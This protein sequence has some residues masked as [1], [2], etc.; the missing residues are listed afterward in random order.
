MAG[1]IGIILYASCFCAAGAMAQGGY[2]DLSYETPAHYASPPIQEP[3][4]PASV[5]RMGSGFADSGMV[6]PGMVDPT[7]SAP[8][9]MGEAGPIMYAQPYPG[10]GMPMGGEFV[11]TPVSP[12]SGLFL[13]NYNN[14]EAARNGSLFWGAGSLFVDAWI[15]QGLSYSN[16]DNDEQGPVGPNDSEGY[17]MNQLYLSFGRKVEKGCGW[18]FG[19]QI[20]LMYG[21]DYYYASSVGL[22]NT[23]ENAPHWNGNG[24]GSTYYRGGR[25]EY[26]LAMPQI[27]AEVYAPIFCGVDVKIG[28]FYSVMGFESPVAPM[29]FFYSRSYSSLYGMPS[30]MT[31]V[32]TTSR[33]GER[34]NLILGAV[35][36]WNA[37]DTPND[38]FSIVAGFS[39]DSWCK[40]LSFSAIVMTG[41]QNAPASGSATWSEE[42]ANTTL[43]N[44]CAILRL[45]D[46][47]SYTAE[48]VAGFDD[49]E[50]LNNIDL[51][52]F[53]GREWYGFS[54]YLFYRATEQLTLGAR[55]EWFR[56]SN[57]TVVTGGYAVSAT[58]EAADYFAFTLGANWEPNHWFVLR[59]EVRWDWSDWEVVD[60]EESRLGAYDRN[61]SRN[62]FTFG[63]DAIVKF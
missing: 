31:G 18:S 13:H 56:D 37:F 12:C 19:G 43:V 54:N 45:T 26:G 8:V 46:R 44:L 50:V 28:H 42:S 22:E 48:F 49:R 36:E 60:S 33:L 1:I 5:E 61:T 52:T 27:Y 38:H 58:G 40:N 35:N 62:Q 53:Q 7:L 17:Q 25:N 11:E 34:A 39:F 47:L 63:M 3:G 9:V 30:T 23:P 24:A 51:T 21:T 6:E 2:P 55:F 29:N 20:D 10:V 32:M 57:D 14:S 4:V 15:A 59:P 41:D 16:N